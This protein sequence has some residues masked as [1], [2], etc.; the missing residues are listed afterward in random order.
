MIAPGPE[1]L[2]RI[3]QETGRTPET[4]LKWF[5]EQNDFEVLDIDDMAERL[6]V[7]ARIVNRLI[8]DGDLPANNVAGQWLITVGAFADWLDRLETTDN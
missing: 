7:S 8:N 5:T 1:T 3:A 4:V 2:A 6:D